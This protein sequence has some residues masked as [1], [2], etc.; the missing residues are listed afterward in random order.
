MK[1]GLKYIYDYEKENPYDNMLN[2]ISIEEAN[3]KYFL[4]KIFINL[5]LRNKTNFIKR[6]YYGLKYI[7]NIEKFDVII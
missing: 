3:R 6:F 5:K 4:Q 2:P 1:H 7:F